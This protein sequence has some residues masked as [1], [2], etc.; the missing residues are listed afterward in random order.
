MKRHVLIYTCFALLLFSGCDQNNEHPDTDAKKKETNPVKEAPP[1]SAST[2]AVQ[3]VIDSCS[4]LEIMPVD[5][6]AADTSLLRFITHLKKI[7]SEKN[8][9]ALLELIG[10]GTITSHGGGLSGKQDFIGY[11]QLHK[12]PHQSGLWKKLGRVIE[13][14]GCFDKRLHK[15]EFI[16]PYLQAG[17]YFDKGCD[18]DW[19]ITYVCLS[20]STRIYERPHQA[21]KVIAELR[22]GILEGS[23]D[24]KIVDSFIPVHTINRSIQGY[25]HERD[26]YPCA[27]YMLVIGKEHRTWRIKSFSP[28]D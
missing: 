25:V 26:V 11:W 8:T 6:S 7:V 21:D 13:L 14:G 4:A 27:D 9:T 17:H 22:Y 2:L 16:M 28:Y 3:A 5:E 18:L 1:V 24:E 10:P 12:A 23:Y 19:F 20:P 15:T